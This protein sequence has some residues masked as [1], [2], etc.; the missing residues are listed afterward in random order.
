LH[1]TPFFSVTARQ[2][3]CPSAGNSLLS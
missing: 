1:F 2:C 3:L